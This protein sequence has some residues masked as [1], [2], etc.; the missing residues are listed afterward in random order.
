MSFFIIV[1]CKKWSNEH[2][3]IKLITPKYVFLNIWCEFL[4]N[5]CY[6]QRGI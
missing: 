5:S 3:Y 6:K 4:Y 1:F 2:T